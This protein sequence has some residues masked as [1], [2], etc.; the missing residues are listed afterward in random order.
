VNWLPHLI[1]A[2]LYLLWS[3]LAT[4]PLVWHLA[5]A[6]HS[7]GDPLLNT[8][9]L[10]WVVHQ[11]VR[12]PW[13]LYAAN[14]FYPEPESLAFSESLLGIALFA[15]PLLWLTGQPVLTYN[16]LLLLSF[17]ASALAA[18]A[19]AT[20]LLA[21]GPDRPHAGPWPGPALLAGAVYAFGFHRLGEIT[22]LQVL[23]AQWLPLTLLFV[24][25]FWNEGRGRDLGLAALSFTLAM[26]S[27]FYLGLFLVPLLGV[28]LLWL[29]LTHPAGR[30]PDRLWRAALAMPPVGLLLWLVA[31]PYLRLYQQ[32]LER[33]LADAQG[34][35]AIL[36]NYLVVPTTSLL[37]GSLAGRLL[38]AFPT[39]Q[40]LFPGLLTLGLAVGGLGWGGPWRRRLGAALIALTGLVLSL[41]PV[42]RLTPDGPPLL[43]L[44]YRLLYDLIPGYPA[45]RVVGRFGLV[46]MLGLGLLAALGL[47]ALTRR[48]RPG[49]RGPLTLGLTLAVLVEYLAIP[50]PLQPVPPPDR[51]PPVYR[52]LATQP[53]RTPIIELPT[54]EDRW[55]TTPA[56][57]ERQGRYQYFSIFHWRP[58][59]AGYSGF[60]PPAFWELIRR[61]R[62]FP[63]PAALGWLQC[64][65]VETVLLHQ[66]AYPPERWQTIQQRLPLYPALRPRTL[67]GETVVLH[68]EP[69]PPGPARPPHLLV[70]GQVRAGE[71]FLGLLAWPATT[72]QRVPRQ[73][74]TV[75]LLAG[76]GRSADWPL[77]LPDCLA[78]GWTVVG[79]ISPWPLPPGRLS[80]QVE[81]PDWR[82]ATTVQVVG[83]QPAPPQPPALAL[84]GWE[85]AAGPIRPGTVI[86][87]QVL[88][89]VRAPGG[90]GGLI[91]VELRDDR[92]QPVSRTTAEPLAARW[93]PDRW[94]APNLVPDLVSLSVPPDALPGRYHLALTFRAPDGRAVSLGGAT[95]VTPVK[96]AAPPVALPPSPPLVTTDG[97][98]AESLRLRG[99]VVEPAPGGLVATL[100][101]ETLAPV[102]ADYHV[103]VHLTDTAGRLLG[104]HDGP[105]GEGLYATSIWEPGEIVVDRHPIAAGEALPPVVRLRIGL[106]RWPLLE[107]LGV[108]Q[109]T[110][111]SDAVEV[112]CRTGSVLACAAGTTPP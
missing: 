17:W 19:L 28:F 13:H 84:Q 33:T 8:W 63:S 30:R 106:Y 104:Q 20:D 81:G 38:P 44:P 86:P 77:A 109:G 31:Q 53:E 102:T 72:S 70:P 100:Y 25:R 48:C 101:W 88:W 87:L 4:F 55:F 50:Q 67:I 11:A 94:P 65:G 98:F 61:L 27:S 49:W 12:D 108:R 57:L 68:L 89:A 95:V 90:Q 66:D 35:A 15:A 112:T 60:Y 82:L 73:T 97:V 110:G 85:V 78:A 9:I 24:R 58:T 36:L 43:P 39:E 46:A 21:Q 6:V 79:L 56:E 107:R 3:L 47:A 92:G 29:V 42:L 54:I 22:H 2:L 5:D 40:T 74:A 111:W 23:M 69:P 75:R 51:I 26:L 37:Y 34:G 62:D 93:S 91:E 1:A 16:L 105:P 41:G 80:L 71:R 10:A 45:I 52:W 96:V 32:G 64:T 14:I 83:G 59:P 18:Y 76:D 7:H 103:F 99:L